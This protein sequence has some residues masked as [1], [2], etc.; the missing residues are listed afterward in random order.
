MID[1]QKGVNSIWRFQEWHNFKNNLNLS[2]SSHFESIMK[3]LYE[4]GYFT[5]EQ[6]DGGAYLFHLTKFGSEKIYQN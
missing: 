1:K 4:S 2:E 6:Q 5:Q 3:E